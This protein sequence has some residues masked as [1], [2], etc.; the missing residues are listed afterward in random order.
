MT[1]IGAILAQNELDAHG[2]KWRK[3]LDE[4]TVADVRRELD[5]GAGVYSLS[6]LVTLLSGA[7]E[8]YL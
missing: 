2:D 4:V 3:A 7:A 1:D 8:E 5:R 6:R